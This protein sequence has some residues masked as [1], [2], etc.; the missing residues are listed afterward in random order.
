[1][2][3]CR[4]DGPIS[5]PFRNMACSFGGIYALIGIAIFAQLWV[6]D[7]PFWI[8]PL[9]LAFP[10]IGPFVAIGL[11]EVSRRREAGEPLDWAAILGVIGRERDRQM[12]S[13]A[14]VILA[15]FLV[16]MFAAQLIVALFLGND[17]GSSFFDIDS[18]LHS[19]HGVAMC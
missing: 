11:Y 1:M 7:E 10:L 3:P 14:F 17:P 4:P 18:I 19:G 6:W 16:W 13:M 9:A 2:L 8:V 5:A 12:P 15:G